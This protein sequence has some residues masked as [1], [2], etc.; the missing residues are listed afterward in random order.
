[1]SKTTKKTIINATKYQT[2]LNEKTAKERELVR[3]SPKCST[4]S[5]SSIVSDVSDNFVNNFIDSD[6]FIEKNL[7]FRRLYAKNCSKL[8]NQKYLENSILKTLSFQS[9]KWQ[10]TVINNYM[11][12]ELGHT[13]LNAMSKDD[14]VELIDLCY[15]DITIQKLV[16]F[17]NNK[18]TDFK[19]LD[20]VFKIMDFFK[21][22]SRF[23]SENDPTEIEFCNLNNYWIYDTD[24]DDTSSTNSDC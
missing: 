4:S 1:M 8:S 9:S 23:L 22:S 10:T 11:F 7:F 20:K 21:T 17:Y 24:N 12:V 6:K 14:I 15:D 2:E 3:F 19:I 18:R 16:I 5:S 13:T